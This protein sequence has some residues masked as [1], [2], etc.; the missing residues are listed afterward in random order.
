MTNNDP[1][2]PAIERLLR[3][4]SVVI[5]GASARP[6]SA[7]QTILENL[8]LNEFAGPIHLLGR[9]GGH[10]GERPIVTDYDALPE[11]IDLAVLCVPA[12]GA[13]AAI[14]GC[15]RRKVAAA[16]V[17]AAGFAEMGEHGLQAELTQAARR[18][19]VAMLGPNCLGYINALDGIRIN[20]AGAARVARIGA[21]PPGSRAD[22]MVAVI[23]HSGG[24]VS[25]IRSALEARDVAVNHSVSTGNEADLGLADFIEYFSDDADTSAIVLYVEQVRDPAR[26]LAAAAR[27]AAAGKPV[28]MMHPGRGDRARAAVQ[29]HTGAL[30]G[31]YAVMATQ[32]GHAGVA[33][34]DTMDELVDAAELLARYPAPPARG[35]GVLTFS[36]AFCAIANDFCEAIGLDLPGLSDASVAT[37]AARLPPFAPPR[38]PLD[39][40]TQPVFE[41]ELVEFGARVLL[42]DPGLGGLVISIASSTPRLAMAYLRGVIAARDNS[43]RPVIFSLLG[44]RAP[45]ADEF[46]ALARQQ[47][48]ILS[49]SVDRSLRAVSVATR[50]ARALARAARAGGQA[51]VADVGEI[52]PGALAEWRGKEILAR[53]GIASPAHALVGDVE[54]AVAA[55]ARFGGKVALKAQSAALAH[56]TEAG[57]VMLGLADAAAI[58]AAW[59]R[60]M[61]NVAAHSPGLVLDG[62]LVEAMA[63]RGVELVLGARRDPHWG[64]VVLVGIGG[65]AIEAL[66]DVRLLP[67]DLAA[68][69]IVAELRLLRAAR[70]LEGFRGMKAVNL[71]AVAAAVGAVGR[72]MLGRP[73]IA[74]IDINP[75]LATDAGVLALDALIVGS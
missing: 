23:S 70:L 35:P 12:N 55:A 14:E 56:K 21:A 46:M 10:I 25:H 20:F 68:A 52:G 36:G 17:F 74:E 58:R 67:C 43:D 40:T 31:D 50:R 72:L 2:R 64:P 57:A 18:G 27:A 45:L 3:P 73:E 48:V 66:G 8:T 47:R 42:A 51:G 38:N 13:V 71:D 60:L 15:A 61:D 4:R 44:D 32:A 63:P 62:V 33:V 69:D 39:L 65:I 34:V 9:A 11:G 29:S 28:L 5:V 41:P 30:A 6:G 16:V 53:L 22:P 26:F 59:A 24:L 54:A 7:G 37:L 19:G 75:L 1:N 49:R